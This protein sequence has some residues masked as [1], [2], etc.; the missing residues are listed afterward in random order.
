MDQ[1]IA[2]L[3]VYND[4]ANA[5]VVGAAKG[6]SDEHLDRKFE[7]GMGSLRRTLIHIWAGE[8][9]W[10]ERW[11]AK[12]ETKWPDEK[13][14]IGVMALGERLKAVAR[15]R[16]AFLANVRGETM[17]KVQPYRDSKGTLYKATLHDM[18][19]QMFVHSTHHRAQAVNMLRHVGAVMPVSGN[20][21]GQ[22]DYMMMVRVPA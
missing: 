15:D 11:R 17:A 9:V 22:V 10:L 7:M 13:E 21:A 16:D 19:L 3:F 14:T 12:A 6:L 4:R 20:S 18:V 2:A 5:L 1:T 8:S